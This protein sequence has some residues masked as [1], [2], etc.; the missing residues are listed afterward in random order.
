M[1]LHQINGDGAG[2]VPHSFSRLF[3]FSYLSFRPYTC[4]VSGDGVNTFQAA[5]VTQQVPGK[6]GRSQAK[7][8]DFPL[9][10]QIPAYAFF[11]LRQRYRF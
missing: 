10:A 9:T 6:N 3:S 2:F 1:T 8:T 7:A 4:D 11:F 5:T